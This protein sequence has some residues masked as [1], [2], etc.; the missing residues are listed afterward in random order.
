M[1]REYPIMSLLVFLSLIYPEVAACQLKGSPPTKAD[2]QSFIGIPENQKRFNELVAFLAKEGVERVVD[3]EELVRQGTDWKSL[4]VAPFV[5]PP[6]EYWPRIVP[7][8]K[9]I[10]RELKPAMGEFE[11]MSGYRTPSYNKSA[12]GAKN[13]RHQYF[14]ALDLQPKRSLTRAETH[15]LLDPI[16]RAKGKA[17][18][19]GLGLYGGV[20]FHVDTYRYRTWRS[21]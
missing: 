6:K 9:F 3:P 17:Y 15:A 11:V 21:K 10:D 5:I 12:G 4:K 20:R 16:W 2:F 19:L 18:N 8:L 7:V 1:L 13:S 14:E